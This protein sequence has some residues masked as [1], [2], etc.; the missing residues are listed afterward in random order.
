[1]NYSFDPL[2]MCKSDPAAF[3]HQQISFGEMEETVRE[4]RRGGR[5]S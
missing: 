1:M 3:G 4:A 2:G 5:A